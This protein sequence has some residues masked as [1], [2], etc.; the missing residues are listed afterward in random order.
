MNSLSDK[1]DEISVEK[2]QGVWVNVYDASGAK[3]ERI[4]RA[5]LET[6]EIDYIDS[7][8]FQRIGYAPAP[9]TMIHYS[10]GCKIEY[11]QQIS[12][13]YAFNRLAAKQR[14]RWDALKIR[15]ENGFNVAAKRACLPLGKPRILI[16]TDAVVKVIT[17]DGERTLLRNEGG[18]IT[19]S[20]KHI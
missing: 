12:V 10:T 5:N 6:G 2:L 11:W 16:G 9:L 7:M 18:Y 20:R 3:L 17:P 14:A 15:I 19:P 8:G 4:V 1:I 13:L